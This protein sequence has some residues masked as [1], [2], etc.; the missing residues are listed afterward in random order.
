MKTSPVYE[1]NADEYN[2]LLANALKQIEEFK[3]PEWS[4][5]VK[6]GVSRIKPPQEEDFWFKRAASILRQAYVKN[7]VGVNRLKTRYGSK[8]NRGMKPER[9]RKASGKMI[10]IMLQQAETAGLLEKYNKPGKR[11]GRK[12]TAKGKELMDSIGKEN[13]QKPAETI[14]D[15]SKEPVSISDKTSSD[16]GESKDNEKPEEI[17]QDIEVKENKENKE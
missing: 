5:F 3:A 6:T 8:Y 16:I 14:T 12:L 17:K 7:I 11:A 4:Y 13:T 9:F 1:L 10:R 15:I 2:K